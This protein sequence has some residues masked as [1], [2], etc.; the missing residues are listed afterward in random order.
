MPSRR[1]KSRLYSCAVCG[2]QFNPLSVKAKFCSGTCMRKGR[3]RK[4]KDA[5]WSLSQKGYIQGKVFENGKW[6]NVKQH[7]WIMEKRLGRKLSNSEHVHHIDHKK[8][9]NSISNL[10]VM[11]QT[12]HCTYHGLNQ[13]HKSGYKMNLTLEQRKRRSE[14]AKAMGLGNLGRNAIAA[15]GKA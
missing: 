12:H 11:S 5:Y 3:I 10:I 14:R 7:R 15:Q 9:N 2:K 8:T 6:R 4:R 13:I 1:I